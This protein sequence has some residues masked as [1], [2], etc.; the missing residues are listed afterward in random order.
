[1]T[2]TTHPAYKLLGIPYHKKNCGALV[3]E[4]FNITIPDIPA[5]QL[6]KQQLLQEKIFDIC[7][8]TDEPQHNGIIVCKH[9]TFWHVGITLYIDHEWYVLH[10]TRTVGFSHIIPLKNMV[11]NGYILYDYYKMPE[12]NPQN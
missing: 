8:Q 12:T 5:S 9:R 1:M 7:E 10:T 11:Q 2:S 6:K 4:Y 3:A